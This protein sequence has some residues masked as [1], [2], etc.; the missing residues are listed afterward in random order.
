MAF[1]TGTDISTRQMLWEQGGTVRGLNIYIFDDMLWFGGYDLNVDGDGAPSWGFVSTKVP[2]SPNTVYVVTHMFDADNDGDL[3]TNDGTIYGY[4]NGQL[5]SVIDAV[6]GIAAGPVGSLHTH[7]DAPGLGALNGGSYNENGTTSGTGTQA[8]LGDMVEFVAYNEI[9]NDAERIIV[10]NYLGSKYFANLAVNDY[11]DYQLNHGKEVIG[12]GRDN[13]VANIHN[14]SQGRNIFSISANTVSFDTNQEYFLIGNDNADATMWTVTDAPNLG[15]RTRRISREWRADH[16]GD[17]GDITLTFDTNDLPT[18]L[19][20]YS[21][22]C[23]VIDASN[24]AVSDFNQASTQ[25]LEMTNTAGSEYSIT[26]DIPNGA[27]VT[28]AIIDPMV[29][30]VNASESGFELT[31]IGVNN[32]IV[33]NAKLNYIPITPVTVG[34]TVTDNTATIGAAPVNDYDNVTPIPGAGALNFPSGIQIAAVN[35]SIM[36]DANPE[37]TEDFNL[38][39]SNS[40]LTPG[41]DIGSNSNLLYTIFDDDN[42]PK[43]GF[44]LTTSSEPESVGIANVEIVRTGSTVNSASVEY[45]L[46]IPGGSGTAIS[47]T[48]YTFVSG[49]AN[50]PASGTSFLIPIAITEDLFDEPNETIIIEL[51]NNIDADIDAGFQEH[52]L[53]IIDN[54][55]PPTVTFAIPNSQGPETIGSPLISVILSGP[56]NQ[57]VQVD[58]EDVLTG[59]AT[60]GMDYTVPITGTL[61]F[62]PGDTLEFLPLIVTNDVIDESDET[63]SFELISGSAINATIGVGDNH[64]YTIKDYTSFEWLGAAGVGQEVDNIFWLKAGNQ[65][66]LD[67]GSVSTFNDFS[68]NNVGVT[69]SGGNRPVMDFAG[70]NGQKQLIFDGNDFF[71]IGDNGSINTS[72]FFTQK[73][74]WITFTTGAD[75]TNRQMIYEQGGGT[76]GISVYIENSEIY[77]NIW[78]NANDNGAGSAWGTGSPTG[79]FEVV[80][81]GSKISNNSNYIA[82]LDYTIDAVTGELSGYLNGELIGTSILSTTSGVPPRLYSHGD[83]GAVGGVVGSTRYHDNTGAA[84]FFTGSVQELIH[85]SDAPV[86][87]ARRIIIDNHLSSKYDISLESNQFYNTAYADKYLNEV[88][89]I[90]Q[91]NTSESHTN[92]QGTS[93][94]RISNPTSLDPGDYLIWGHDSVKY[95]A[96]AAPVSWLLPPG[97]HNALHR[98]W[99]VSELGGDVG[100]VDMRFDLSQWSIASP[101]DLYL[102]VDSDDGDFVNATI[103]PATSFASNVALFSGINLN[104]GQWFTIGTSNSNNPLP[105]ELLTFEALPNENRVNLSWTTASEINSDYYVIERSKDMSYWTNITT[106]AGAG[107]SSILLKYSDVDLRPLSGISYYR[108]KQVDVDGTYIYSEAIAVN[109]AGEKEVIIYPNPTSYGDGIINLA[110]NK[111]ENEDLTIT[112]YD[113]AGRVTYTEMILADERSNLQT[114]F[115]NNFA[116]GLYNVQ[117]MY[118]ENLILEKLIIE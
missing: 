97:I 83:N 16:S 101:D 8:F 23:L 9:L 68:P 54:D 3:S 98:R 31:G 100:D 47:G 96:P 72:T 77:Y 117:L 1:R 95:T 10:E 59:S 67:G 7:P 12:I 14:N 114:I 91:F 21:K 57:I 17:L 110:F 76:R 56:S 105:I 49:T 18:L 26:T 69:S 94:V 106:Q 51:Y 4:L 43:V 103:Y 28:I 112:I 85:F 107:N 109:R 84:T 44:A 60:F 87:N 48:D 71:D 108:L 104:N 6:N 22:Y 99:R 113:A 58:Y 102:M 61:V 24:G 115:L 52:E 34:L 30:F 38:T 78:S 13:G 55:S 35:F 64:Q 33:V 116:K 86:N 75:V 2:I 111:Y 50:F 32:P 92:A 90:G 53:T 40:G 73:S 74:I 15:L 88:A 81:T 89:G 80:S 45:R 5:F 66:E 36:G 37:V 25:I 20:T 42:I 65:N 11:F 70:P 39:L 41:I 62:T 27:Y 19:G 82:M 93:I 29:E 118:G 63:I 79:S 46:R